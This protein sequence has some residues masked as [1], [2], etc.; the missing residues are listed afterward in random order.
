MH[1]HHGHAH[2]D[3]GA[4]NH[5]HGHAGASPRRLTI[6]LVI[7]GVF[8]LIEAWGGWYAHS[9]A[10]LAE[11]AHMLADSASLL[12]AIV[13]IHAARRPPSPARSYGSARFQTLAAYTN[14]LALIV[15]TLFVVVEAGRRL[16]DPPAVDAPVML[17]VAVVGA[18]ANFCAYMAL[19]GAHSLNE[20]GARAHV[21]SD[22]LG[23]VAAILAAGLIGLFGWLPADPLL[24]LGVSALILRSGWR[25]TR[26]AGHVLLEGAPPSLDPAH[27]SG[28]V[29]ALPGVQ[30]VHHVHVWS[31][32]GDVPVVSLHVAVGMGDDDA[33]LQRVHDY[34]RDEFDVTHAT[35][36]I[37]RGECVDPGGACHQLS[38]ETPAGG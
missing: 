33:V 6:A 20:R 8:T 36:Q 29:A 18:I 11:A 27:L 34:L 7:L 24:S 19:A 17:V 37:E 4:H 16:L 25:L 9:V 35:V 15:L 38:D 32:T 14:G 5:A 26:E 13:A 31:L 1:D 10:L 12:L 21:A 23:S 2:V 28:G 22:L 30:G 3:H